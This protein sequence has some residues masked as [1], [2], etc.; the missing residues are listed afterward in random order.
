MLKIHAKKS[1]SKK[2]GHAHESWLKKI[3]G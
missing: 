3:Q 1:P 2:M